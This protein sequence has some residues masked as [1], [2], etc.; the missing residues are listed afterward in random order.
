MDIKKLFEEKNGTFA[1]KVAG[2]EELK[3]RIENLSENGQHPLSLVI[4]CSDSRVIPESIFSASFGELFVIRTAGNVI[5]EGELGS[6]EY[7]VRHLHVKCIFVLGHTKCGAVHAA[8]HNERGDYLAP[9]LN[10]IK[11]A[12]KDETDEIKAAEKN[13]LSTAAYIKNLFKD[14]EGCV[15]CGIY[16][17]KT[18]KVGL[19]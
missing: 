12:I 4:A 11:S 9:I 6:I 13:A 7:A 14:F 8:I 16:D 15:L 10:R 17:I 3:K 19:L 1:E 2:D 18:G 5:N